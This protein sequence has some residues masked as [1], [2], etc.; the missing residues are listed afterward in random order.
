[1][2]LMWMPVPIITL[3]M[4]VGCNDKDPRLARMAEQTTAQ[5]AAQNQQSA[6]LNEKV[7]QN[8]R[9]MVEAVERSRQ[10]LQSLQHELNAQRSAV[11][12]QRQDLAARQ[13]RE[14]LL[15]PVFSSLG[16]ILAAALPL[17]LA[18]YLLHGL[19]SS[20]PDAELVGQLLVEDIVREHPVLLSTP[21]TAAI[22]QQP[23]AGDLVKTTE[24]PF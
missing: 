17:V 1:M 13:Y 12:Q 18:W 20:N 24:P 7:V 22:D 21:P 15:A 11:D 2:K 10:D 6:Q 19:R 16:I 23:Q 8:H 9:Q 5:Q 4:I 3:A 14:S